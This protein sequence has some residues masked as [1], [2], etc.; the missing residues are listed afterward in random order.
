MKKYSTVEEYIASFPSDIQVKLSKLREIVFE[1]APTAQEYL[2]YGMPGYKLNGK[3][4]IYFASFKNHLGIY[5]TPSG[6]DAFASE[7][8]EYKTAKG[9]IQFPH[10]KPFPFDLFTKIVKY[11]VQEL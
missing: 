3:P 11:R 5:P 6:V 4:L 2:G 10:D 1:Y 8:L 7:L 9:S